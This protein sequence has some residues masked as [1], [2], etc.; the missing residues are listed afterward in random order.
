MRTRFAGWSIVKQAEEFNI[1]T[2]TVSK[3]L[4]ELDTLYDIV[5]ANSIILPTRKKSKKEVEMDRI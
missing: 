3:C 2:D 1:S 5:Q 4:K